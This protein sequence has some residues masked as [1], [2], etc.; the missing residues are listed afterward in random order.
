MQGETVKLDN[1]SDFI[2]FSIKQKPFYA[3]YRVRLCNTLPFGSDTTVQELV[4]NKQRPI[5]STR[6]ELVR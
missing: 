1:S 6:L 5:S 3:I 4:S 2:S